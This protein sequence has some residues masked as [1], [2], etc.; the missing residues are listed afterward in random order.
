MVFE[1]AKS[2]PN[3]VTRE[4]QKQARAPVDRPFL[5]LLGARRHGWRQVFM[6]FGRSH[7]GIS[8]VMQDLIQFSGRLL[9]PCVHTPI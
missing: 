5:S 9:K 8:A 6:H 1:F 3:Q 4:G 7:G 2:L